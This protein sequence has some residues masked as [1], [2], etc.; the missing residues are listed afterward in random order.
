MGFYIRKSVS[1]GPFR[2]NLSRSGL[3]VS[4]GVK[5]FRIGSGP[6]GNYVHMGRG[7]LYYRASLGRPRRASGGRNLGSTP[8]PPAQSPLPGDPLATVEIGNVLEMSPS[9]GSEIVRQISEKMGRV[10]LWPWV[11]G[12]GLASAVVL[13]SEPA[14]QPFALVLILCT[15]ALSALVAY[16]DVQRKTVVILYD[17]N[18]EIVSSLQTFANEFDKVAS[19][20][21]IWNI[22]SAGRTFDWKRN[23]GAGRLI[24]R[25]RATFGYSVPKVIK[26][27]LELPSI[28]GGRQAVYF[29]PD[30]VLITEGKNA[31]AISYDDLN[32]YWNTTVFIE[33]DRVP[34]DAQVVGYTWQ[35]VNRDGGPDRRFSN[36]RRIPRVLYQQMGL[37][38]TGGFQKILHISRV[39]DRGGFDTALAGL[40]VLI[41]C[42]VRDASEIKGRSGDHL[43][44][45]REALSPKLLAPPTLVD[46][47]ASERP[48][49]PANIRKGRAPI[50][51]LLL[52]AVGTVFAVVLAFGLYFRFSTPSA[53]GPTVPVALAPPTSAYP[54]GAP[55]PVPI[56]L[57]VAYPAGPIYTGPHAAPDL[58]EPQNY[59]FRTRI[60]AASRKAPNFAG[61]WVLV[62]WGCG[63]GCNDGR[64]VNIATG[65]VLSLPAAV[66]SGPLPD[67]TADVYTYTRESRLLIVNGHD[68]ESDITAYR[69]RCYVLNDG[70]TPD[71]TQQECSAPATL[72]IPY[73]IRQENMSSPTRN[74]PGSPSSPQLFG[75]SDL[76]H[77]PAP[78]TTPSKC[79][80]VYP[81]VPPA[82]CFAR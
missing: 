3:G 69:P 73:P 46:Q 17:L 43:V 66:I 30:V 79:F 51:P 71:L 28:V 49:Q 67:P 50:L 40:R 81:A 12:G 11:L 18:E 34:S 55:H 1:A 45:S 29:F 7:G 80:V 58:T 9:N 24:T 13:A 33:G 75:S 10:R 2:F 72:D 53:I 52:V 21:T 27:N 68:G 14:G 5:G 64:L 25:K 76:Y 63:T 59:N 6:R 15:M 47:P 77:P 44:Q 54:G 23:A 36:N 8:Y 31:G 19:A 65:T 32:A 37:Q 4:V 48:E 35:F 78:A 42:L 60:R 62:S 82:D 39:E 61:R 56:N 41:S 70:V 57:F 38:G 26:T 16:L 22:D 20:S 74:S